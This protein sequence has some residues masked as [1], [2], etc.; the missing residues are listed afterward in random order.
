M[1]LPMSIPDGAE[2]EPTTRRVQKTFAC[3]R[4]TASNSQ[5]QLEQQDSELLSELEQRCAGSKRLFKLTSLCDIEINMEPQYEKVGSITHFYSKPSVAVV[6]LSATLNKGDKI[7]I[8]GSTTNIEQSVDSIEI[9]HKQIPSAQAGQS[10]G[11]KVLDRVREGDVVYR[12][13][14][15]A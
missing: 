6:E 14:A 7:V 2:G 13:K 4:P 3:P 5:L 11:M 10:I 1:I 9:E 8:R 15:T 12:V